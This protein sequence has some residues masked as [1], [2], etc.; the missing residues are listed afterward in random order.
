MPQD[1][2][3]LSTDFGPSVLETVRLQP[4]TTWPEHRRPNS[5][6]PQALTIVLKVCLASSRLWLP[7][8]PWA[9]IS[10][11]NPGATETVHEARITNPNP[12]FVLPRPWGETALRARAIAENR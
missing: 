7:N 6:S 8:S 3:S 11:R 5:T 1:Q 4:A 10:R 2:R 9:M 12:G